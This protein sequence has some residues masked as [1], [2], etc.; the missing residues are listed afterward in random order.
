MTS[1]KSGPYNAAVTCHVYLCNEVPAAGENIESLIVGVAV[2]ELS[3]AKFVLVIDEEVT[4]RRETVKLLGRLFPKA[5]FFCARC[6][7]KISDEGLRL[8]QCFRHGFSGSNMTLDNIRIDFSCAPP[9][10]QMLLELVNICNVQA[11]KIFNRGIPAILRFVEVVLAHVMSWSCLS[12]VAAQIVGLLTDDDD[13]VGRHVRGVEDFVVRVTPLAG[14]ESRAQ[15]N[16]VIRSGDPPTLGHLKLV[17]LSVH[18]LSVA[19]AST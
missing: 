2:Y 10:E 17:E 8:L 7:F 13:C 15:R 1:S 16:L 5:A 3:T 11:F 9:S 19:S 12:E 18:S 4:S 6:S 14:C